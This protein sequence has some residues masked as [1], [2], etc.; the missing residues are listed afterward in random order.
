MSISSKD[1]APKDITSF[2]GA[3]KTENYDNSAD[4]ISV[5]RPHEI[6]DD[7]GRFLCGDLN[8]HIDREGTWFYLGTPIGRK[9]LVKLF[10][11]VIHRDRDGAYWLITPAEKGRI[12][13][14][15][16]PF[17]AVEMT[18]SD[19]GPAQNLAFRT[20]VDDIV[21][22]GPAHPIRIA[23]DSRTGEPAPYILVR[24]TLEAKLTRSVFYHLVDLGTEHDTSK[25]KRFGVWSDGTFFE[26]G[27]LEGV[28]E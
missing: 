9:E 27:N 21:M 19:E 23:E 17:M 24:D 5:T 18:V 3:G 1:N 22:A 12:R 11:T 2:F 26:L 25:G 14:E 7:N 4:P 20:N 10:S 28:A 16:A 15:D 6:R 8:I 13:V